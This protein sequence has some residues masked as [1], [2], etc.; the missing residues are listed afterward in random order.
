MPTNE[1][2]AKLFA[3]SGIVA[4]VEA[5]PTNN[6]PSRRFTTLKRVAHNRYIGAAHTIMAATAINESWNE[7]SKSRCESNA[8]ITNAV[9][10][11]MLMLTYSRNDESANCNIENIIA[12][13][14]ALGEVPQSHT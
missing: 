13:R 4:S 2:V 3:T 12:A 11:R 5:M 14:I 10:A 9:P 1:I 8:N 7:I 6:T